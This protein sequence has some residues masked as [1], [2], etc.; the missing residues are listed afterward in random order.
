[1]KTQF[2]TGTGDK[3][4][5][6]IGKKTFDKD[7][8]IFHIL[9]SLDECNS[10]LGIV[11]SFTPKEFKD[12]RQK[13]LSH[14]VNRLQQMVFIAQAETAT[15]GFGFGTYES[16]KEKEFHR[17]KTTHVAEVESIIHILDEVLPELKHFIVPGGTKQ[18][19]FLDLARTSARRVERYAVAYNKEKPFSPEYLQFMNRLSS[20]FFVLARYS[21][22]INGVE[23]EAPEYK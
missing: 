1:M 16:A 3:G 20:V 7:D 2:Y 14:F 11:K 23:E 18:A 6:H 22:F 15:L 10:M 13:T 8:V 4:Q 17:I 12:K 21:N 19:A 5:S 9:G